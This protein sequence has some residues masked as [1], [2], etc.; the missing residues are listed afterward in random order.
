MH[1]LRIKIPVHMDE[2]SRI[3]RKQSDSPDESELDQLNRDI[4][5][6]IAACIFITAAILILYVIILFPIALVGK[7]LRIKPE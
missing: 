3:E 5:F 7:N 4:P 1:N 2:F 6:N